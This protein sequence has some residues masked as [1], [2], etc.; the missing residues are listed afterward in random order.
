MQIKIKTL[1][2]IWTG[3]VNRDCTKL[4]ETSIIGSLRWWFEA[5]VRGLG[6]NACDPTGDS[7]CE[8]KNDEK[9]VCAVCKLFGTTNWAKIF[10]FEINQ[11]FSK[12]YE[13]NLVISGGSRDWYYPSGLVSCDGSANKIEQILPCYIDEEKVETEPVLK[14]LLTFISKWGMIGGKTAIGYGVVRFE[15]ENSKLLRVGDDDVKMFFNYLEQKKNHGKNAENAPKLNEMFFAKFEVKENC[16]K[17][18]FEKIEKSISERDGKKQFPSAILKCNGIKENINSAEDF[19]RRL[20]DCYGFIPSSA[21]IRKELRNIL[22]NKD[23][24][25]NYSTFLK[26]VPDDAQDKF[27]NQLRHFLMGELGRFSAIQISHIYWTGKNWEFRILGWIPKSLDKKF[28]ITR[29][30]IITFIKNVLNDPNFWN[31]TLGCSISGIT[32]FSNN[33]WNFIDLGNF[34]DIREVKEAL[35]EMVMKNE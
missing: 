7:K 26:R 8:Y 10:K 3:G 12:I 17:N 13:G 1:T 25:N 23:E 33:G 18:I 5:I 27:L 28:G 29:N 21:L 16:I 14:V 32:E 30:D 24:F 11:G 22:R 34:G 31:S 2:P 19:L 6:G 35:K 20:K 9:D 15:D 4:R